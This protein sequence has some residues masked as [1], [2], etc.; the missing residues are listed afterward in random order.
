MN[1]T[2]RWLEGAALMLAL[3]IVLVIATLLLPEH[4]W[5]RLVLP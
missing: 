5:D 3:T 4:P 2:I 1:T